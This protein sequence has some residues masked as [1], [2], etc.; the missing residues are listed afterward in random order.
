MTH[1]A[2]Y[3]IFVS[4]N[5][6]QNSDLLLEIVRAEAKSS[7]FNVLDLKRGISTDNPAE[8]ARSLLERGDIEALLVLAHKESSW[9]SNE[10]GMAY[11]FRIPIYVISNTS[12]EMDGIARLITSMKRADILRPDELR[13]ALSEALEILK[14]KIQDNRKKLQEPAPPDQPIVRISWSYFRELILES[15][16]KLS[17]D[18][19]PNQM[20]YRPT[21]ILGISR[22]GI[23]VADIISRLSGDRRLGLLEADRG[24]CESTVLYPTEPTKTILRTH[25]SGLD[26]NRQARILVVDDVMKSGR[27]LHQAVDKI[28]DLLRVVDPE[29]RAKT[30]VKSLVLIVRGTPPEPAPD[31]SFLQIPHDKSIVLPYGLG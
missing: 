10:I 31:Y 4:L 30:L 3:N 7:G 19:D 24:A 27:S 5:F 2:P 9:M 1:V 16:K 11:A 26:T 15:Y 23:I 29:D 21:L 22:G 28:R 17:M 20:G 12:F 25:L 8:A 18:V 14:Q 13:P 6:T